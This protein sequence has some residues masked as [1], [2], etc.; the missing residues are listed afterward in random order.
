[1]TLHTPIYGT[2]CPALVSLWGGEGR[3]I[4]WRGDKYLEMFEG[5]G[6]NM[7]FVM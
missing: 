5:L 2:G 1:M 4:G 7:Y 3:E 6:R